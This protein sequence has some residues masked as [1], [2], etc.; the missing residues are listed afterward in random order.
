M[1]QSGNVIVLQGREP[2][3][4]EIETWTYVPKSLRDANRGSEPE[5]G[6][7]DPLSL[8]LSLRESADER[9]VPAPEQ[10]LEN[11]P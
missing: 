10:M 1:A 3:C 6:G 11:L 7:V 2:D 8:Y 9:M 4:Y 5:Q